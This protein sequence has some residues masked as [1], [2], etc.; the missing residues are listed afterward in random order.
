MHLNHRCIVKSLIGNTL[1][2]VENFRY[3]GSEISSTTKD[4][5]SI[6]GKAWIA[7]NYHKLSTI[8]KYT[9]NL[10]LKNNFFRVTVKNILLYE[11]V[12]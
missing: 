7:L 4:V 1:K 11:S 10:W 9:A 3:L 8:C 2:Q 6:N 12:T 5:S